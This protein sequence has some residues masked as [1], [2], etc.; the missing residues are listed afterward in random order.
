MYILGIHD[1]HNATAC[2]LKD[3]QIL[4]CLQEERFSR[5]K[6]QSGFPLRAVRA[7][8]EREGLSLRDLDVIA[9]AGISRPYAKKR[10]FDFSWQT[11]SCLIGIRKYI[12]KSLYTVFRKTRAYVAYKEGFKHNERLV[13]LCEHFGVIPQTCRTFFYD[14]H[15]AH[16]ACAYY[17]SPYAPEDSVL[18]LTLDGEGD[19]VCATVNIAKG[20]TIKRIAETAA[21]NSIGNVYSAVTRAMGFTALE[22]EYKLMG[23][24]PHAD[25]RYS[26]QCADIFD[27]F[28]SVDGLC[29]CRRIPEPTYKIDNRY[30]RLFRKKRFDSICAGLQDFTERRIV[31]WVQNIIRETGVKKLAVSGGVFMNVKANKKIAELDIDEL[32]IMPSCGDESNSIGAAFLASIDGNK[33]DYLAP[34]AIDDI[35]WGFEYSNTKIEDDLRVYRRALDFTYYDQIEKETARLLARGKIVARFN[36]RMEFGA[37]ALG[38]R[39]ILADPSNVDAVRVINRMIKKRDFWMPF[40]PIVQDE[41]AAEYLSGKIY[42]SPHMM[43]TFDTTDKRNDIMAAVHS[44]DLTARAQ[45]L[46]HKHNPE[47]YKILSEFRRLTSKAALLNTSFNLHGFPI[48]ESPRD[49]LNVFFRSGL[50][51]LAIGNYIVRKKT[52]DLPK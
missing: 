50:D 38:N 51:F 26:R 22:H 36:G 7:I 16:A 31:E 45:I 10:L 12:R 1:G 42:S 48:V 29:F 27:S 40:A 23:M 35:Y 18:V 4:Y 2:L 44:A 41:S 25:R 20:G 47:L 33:G 14:H 11:G 52:Y 19:G 28:L 30:C 46:E 6:N 37:R 17:C 15:T 34:V 8:F 32:F 9:F 5:H 24:A 21:G 39:S 3:G 43:L 49:A 13:P